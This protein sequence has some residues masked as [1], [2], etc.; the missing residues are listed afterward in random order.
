MSCVVYL[1][2]YV[3]HEYE[4]RLPNSFFNVQ[5]R[6]EGG[7][8]E[9]CTSGHYILA[10]KIRWQRKCRVAENSTA[11]AGLNGY[12][13]RKSPYLKCKMETD[14]IPSHLGPRGIPCLSCDNHSF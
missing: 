2:S 10:R 11:E 3:N 7:R 6:L 5:R 12:S 8:S 13:G 4:K 1:F 14:Q 9:C